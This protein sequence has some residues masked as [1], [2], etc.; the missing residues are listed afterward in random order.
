VAFT[1]RSNQKKAYAPTVRQQV[2][3]LREDLPT[4]FGR[5]RDPQIPPTRQ[6]S[7]VVRPAGFT[8]NDHVIQALSP[9]GADH[10]SDVRTLPRRSWRSRHFLN[11][12]LSHLPGEIGSEDAVAVAQ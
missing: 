8:E 3:R 6:F 1:G 4:A 11:A 12:K 9:T 10:P 7:E 2:R 5:I